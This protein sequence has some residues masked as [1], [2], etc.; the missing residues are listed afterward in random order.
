M[1]PRSWFEQA[2]GM[3]V[4]FLENK[5]MFAGDGGGNRELPR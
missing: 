1:T 2:R 4:P 5:E 3:V